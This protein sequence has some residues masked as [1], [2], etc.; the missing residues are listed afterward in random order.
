MT[1]SRAT[2][3]LA[4]AT[5]GLARARLVRQRS[6]VEGRMRSVP[7]VLRTYQTRLANLALLH[8]TLVVLPTGAGKTLVAADVIRKRI[9]ANAGRAVFF[10]PTVLLVE[11]QAE[12]LRGWLGPEKVI[13]EF[14]GGAQIPDSFDALVSTPKAFLSQQN[15]GTLGFDWASFGTVVFDE[16]HH[17]LKEHPYRKLALD[18]L[19]S[20][21]TPRVIGLSAS[22]TY[23]VT[24]DSMKKAVQRIC[25]ELKISSPLEVVSQQELQAAGYHG[26]I[27]SPIM[28]KMTLSVSQLLPG[29]VPEEERK[30][31]HL[32]LPK[33]LAR[34]QG[35]TA[36]P[37][38]M[39]LMA[40]V[41]SMEKDIMLTDTG[42]QSPLNDAPAAAW[43]P[44]AHKRAKKLTDDLRCAELE[45]WYEALK[46]L[47]TSWEEM[48]DA[49]VTLL[50]MFSSVST[51]EATDTLMW[52]AEV[53]AKLTHFWGDVPTSFQRFDHLA[54]V[55]LEE[56]HKHGRGDEFR[57]ILFVQRKLMTHVLAHVI[58]QDPELSRCFKPT[59]LYAADSPVT[60]SIVLSKQAAAQSLATFASG[61]CNLLIATVAAEEG[62]DIA[63]AN[64]VIRFDPVIH[65]V[66]FQQ[67]RGRGRQAD[68]SFII[69]SERED[70][71]IE[72]L[73]AG[74]VA[75]KEFLHEF[76]PSPSDGS[77]LESQRK[78]QANRE[79][80]AK[81]LFMKDVDASSAIAAVQGLCQKTKAPLQESYSTSTRGDVTCK[82]VYQSHLRHLEAEKTAN[83]KKR[84]KQ[85]AAMS[86]WGSLKLAISP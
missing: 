32:M 52:S 79:R 48:Q 18:L 3:Q 56:Y 53:R 65:G 42:F 36:T 2:I 50:R 34:V 28:R 67:G 13:A 86:L 64:C 62:M 19:K 22:L 10:V 75:Q 24:E 1:R 77:S 15:Q 21:A 17:V 78:A 39:N 43:G 35:G 58:G 41:H 37:M 27:A 6:R 7:R 68:S 69:M 12:A 31:A 45:H 54:E 55:L 40:C 76:Q 73:A 25:E 9:D 49:A 59:C 33:F 74:E 23:A 51:G 44:Y 63:A 16:V 81:N 29:L 46:V 80:S 8:N 70:R 47:V 30:Q 83:G 60:P 20:N 26:V 11:Q 38:A 71:T 66:S 57:G 72:R 85:L 14:M 4:A 5:E 84:A 82:L 61:R